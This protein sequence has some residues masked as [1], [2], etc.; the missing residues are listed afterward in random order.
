MKEGNSGRVLSQQRWNCREHQTVSEH[1][2]RGSDTGG[3]RKRSRQTGQGA[4]MGA[5]ITGEPE[6][7]REG[8]APRSREQKT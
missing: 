4:G 1:T 7:G 5:D 2:E 8:F 6:G 3:D